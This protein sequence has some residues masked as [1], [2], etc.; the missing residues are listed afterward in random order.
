LLAAIGG[1]V[2]GLPLGVPGLA[3]GPTAYFL[4]RSSVARVDASRGALGGRGMAYTASVLGVVATAIGA[5]TSLA[6]FVYI[7]LA[8]SGTPPSG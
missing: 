6:W 2:L 4:G 5:I 3:L 8:I 7:L 1:I